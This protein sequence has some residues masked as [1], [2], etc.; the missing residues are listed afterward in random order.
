MSRLLVAGCSALQSRFPATVLVCHLLVVKTRVSKIV[1]CSSGFRAETS[2]IGHW[3]P[4]FVIFT[5]EREKTAVS[6]V[7]QD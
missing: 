3:I 2:V 1:R 7:R 4:S 6:E 5:A